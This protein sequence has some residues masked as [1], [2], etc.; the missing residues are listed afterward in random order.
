MQT[1]DIDFTIAAWFNSSNLATNRGLVTKWGAGPDGE[2]RLAWEVGTGLRLV[3]RNTANTANAIVLSS[4]TIGMNTW[5][6]VVAWHDSVNNQ[7]AIAVNDGTPVTTGH[8]TGVR[9]AALA[10]VIGAFNNANY[11]N[12]LIDEVGLWKR[13]LTSGERTDLYNGGSGRDYAYIA[14]AAAGVPKHFMHYQRMRAI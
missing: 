10:F 7:I 5:Y 3:V 4:E 6:H 13:V 2:Y 11:F 14:G 9:T 1:G 8:S 12:G